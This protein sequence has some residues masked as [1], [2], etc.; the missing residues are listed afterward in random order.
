MSHLRAGSVPWFRL[1]CTQ[2]PSSQLAAEKEAGQRTGEIVFLAQCLVPKVQAEEEH[3]FKSPAINGRKCMPC[4]P[5][6]TF[7]IKT[8]TYNEEAHPRKAGT[9]LK[10]RRQ[11]TWIHTPASPL[12]SSDLWVHQANSKPWF[13]CKMENLFIELLWGWNHGYKQLRTMPHF[14]CQPPSLPSSQI[15]KDVCYQPPFL[16]DLPYAK[17]YG[18]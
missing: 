5:F 18:G 2:G 16:T 9:M 17:P 11:W 8:Y 3:S 13:F 10:K 12:P 15:I 7:Q 6:F 14:G 1:A 4:V